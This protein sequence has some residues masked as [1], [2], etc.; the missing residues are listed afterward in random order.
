MILRPNRVLP[1]LG[2]ERAQVMSPVPAQFGSSAPVGGNLECSE[3]FPRY[4]DLKILQ[5]FMAWNGFSSYI[6]G[7]DD[8]F[9][10]K[11]TWTIARN[12]HIS[13]PILTHTGTPILIGFDCNKDTI[14]DS[15]LRNLWK[16]DQLLQL[17]SATDTFFL[18]VELQKFKV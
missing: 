14:K 1:R 2:V 12:Y 3:H 15:L 13:W 7:F 16:W 18:A 10:N 11:S 9:F 8:I 6:S 5:T 4:C 17:G